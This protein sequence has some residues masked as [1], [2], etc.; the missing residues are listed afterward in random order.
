[1]KPISILAALVAAAMLPCA[2]CN[3]EPEVAPEAAVAEG[4]EG[5]PEAEEAPAPTPVQGG[6][7]HSTVIRARR[8]TH[9]RMDELQSAR[10]EQVQ[11]EK[12]FSEPAP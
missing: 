10:Q 5:T 8:R 4:V 2:G 7:Y 9:E 3:R 1:M 12:A 6:D 11:D